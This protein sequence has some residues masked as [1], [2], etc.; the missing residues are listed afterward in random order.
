MSLCPTIEASK[1]VC[2]R[3]FHF[4]IWQL[5]FDGIESFV[6]VFVWILSDDK[7]PVVNFMTS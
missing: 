5:G 3:W 6:T 7:E 1:S 2:E 4:A